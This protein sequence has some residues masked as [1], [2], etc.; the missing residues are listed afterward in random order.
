MIG[1]G[2]KNHAKQIDLKKNSGLHQVNAKKNM[3]TNNKK[4]TGREME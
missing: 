3:S 2:E 1:G 4:D